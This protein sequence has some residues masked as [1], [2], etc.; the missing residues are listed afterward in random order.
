MRSLLSRKLFGIQL[1]ISLAHTKHL[2]VDNVR[3]QGL[4]DALEYDLLPYDK[5]EAALDTAEGMLSEVFILAGIDEKN[6]PGLLH[7][8]AGKIPQYGSNVV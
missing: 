8:W 4:A 5:A 7:G 3:I 2:N 1:F 6:T